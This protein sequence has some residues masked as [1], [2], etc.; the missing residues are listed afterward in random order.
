[1]KHV[2]CIPFYAVALVLGIG[3]A[4]GQPLP[5]ADNIVD[6][7]PSVLVAQYGTWPAAFMFVAWQCMNAATRLTNFLATWQPTVRVVHER[8]D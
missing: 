4:H 7:D 8:E 3:V 5:G 2:T 6:V 1:M